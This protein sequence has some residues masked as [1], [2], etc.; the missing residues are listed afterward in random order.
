[1]SKSVQN[2]LLNLTFC[3]KSGM[4]SE[5]FAKLGSKKKLV[6]TCKITG[7]ILLVSCALFVLQCLTYLVMTNRNC[8]C[9][10]YV[11][12]QIIFDFSIT[13]YRYQTSKYFLRL[14]EWLSYAAL[15]P[16]P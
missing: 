6:N 15:S 4:K 5:P 10:C 1:M 3:H 16:G 2:L 8:F 13:K 14:F 12:L 9:F 11:T 7:K